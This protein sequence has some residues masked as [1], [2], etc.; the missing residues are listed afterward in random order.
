MK[1]IKCSKCE[2]KAPPLSYDGL[3]DEGWDIFLGSK[4]MFLCADCKKE[5]KIEVK[6]KDV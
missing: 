2:M 5:K 1:P 4:T 3:R 6:I